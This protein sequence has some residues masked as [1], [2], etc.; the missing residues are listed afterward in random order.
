LQIE[1]QIAIRKQFTAFVKTTIQ[2][3]NKKKATPAHSSPRDKF[4][5]RKKWK[6]L[7]STRGDE[8]GG[9]R[10]GSETASQCTACDLTF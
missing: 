4:W 7:I 5:E 9:A 10:D 6:L 3:L 1:T 8:V 2:R